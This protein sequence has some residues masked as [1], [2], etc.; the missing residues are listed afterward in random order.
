VLEQSIAKAADGY[1]DNK[2]KA[3]CQIKLLGSTGSIDSGNIAAW[4]RPDGKRS[5]ILGIW[6]KVVM[7]DFSQE[8]SKE[9]FLKGRIVGKKVKFDIPVRIIDQVDRCL[10]G[11]ACLTDPEYPLCG[12]KPSQAD[13]RF[14]EISCE[15]LDHICD[16]RIHSHGKYLCTCPVRA[17]IFKK[18]KV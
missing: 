16:F 5:H 13:P 10:K 6:L 4:L 8:K 9:L 1:E 2:I 12:A 11:K 18:Y 14:A 15:T 3:G 17:Y 7:L